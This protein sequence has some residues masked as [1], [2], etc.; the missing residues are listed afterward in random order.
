MTPLV[1]V[2]YGV[3]SA[4]PSV[5]AASAGGCC[6]L[7]WH[8]D[9]ADE[10]GAKMRP[11]LAR[12]GTVVMS[13]PD[14]TTDERA[15]AI[16]AHRPDGIVTFCDHLLVETAEFA[17]RL[18]LR[19]QS[20]SAA[21]P[22]TDKSAQRQVFRSAGLQRL[23]FSRAS[24]PAALA[25]AV[26]EV[27]LPA[28]VKP[29]H[30]YGSSHTFRLAG[31]GDLEA[32]MACLPAAVLADGFI[33]EEE[34]AGQPGVLGDGIGD[35]VSV[36]TVTVGGEHHAVGI[37]GR[38]SLAPP[39]R[40][41]GGFYPSTLAPDVARAV[42]ELAIRALSALGVS[43]GVCHT[44][45]K[46]TPSGPEILEVNGRLGGHV[47]WLLRRHGGPDLIRAVLLAALGCWDPPAPYE[48][49][50]VAFRHV[51]P[52]PMRVGT[53]VS[54]DGIREVRAM[55]CVEDLAM[56]IRRGMVLD[57][58]EGTGSCIAEISGWADS[59]AAMVSYTTQIE[60]KLRVS[61]AE[62]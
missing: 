54:V 7:L 30:G 45:I 32:V 60:D 61:L 48:P 46:L 18:E 34:L 41:R 44:E 9:A 19:Y 27:G 37:V 21:V 26:S 42:M 14:A 25:C 6:D 13:A 62:R 56:R 2:N 38:L 28:V 35:Y 5:I 17:R 8:C 49:A 31:E 59:H 11:V 15:T 52:A 20:P 10:H 53:V 24:S 22:L 47:S 3:G 51:P 4:S 57:W 33:V 1:A 55:T 23:G 36:E 12:L 50:G 16:A 58:R 39:Y 40:E 29:V 43:C